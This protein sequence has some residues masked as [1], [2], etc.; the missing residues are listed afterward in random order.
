MRKLDLRQ[1]ALERQSASA[2]IINLRQL[3]ALTAVA[4]GSSISAAAEGLYRVSSAVTRSSA[5]LEEALGRPLFDRRARGTALNAYGELALKGATRMEQDFEAARSQLVAYGGFGARADV[6]SVFASILYERRLAI[7]ASQAEKRNM[8]AVAREFGITQPVISVALKDL[9]TGLGV[10]LFQRSARAD[11]NVHQRDCR[12]QLQAGAGPVAP[13]PAR[14]LW[15]A[16]LCYKAVLTSARCCS[17]E[18]KCCR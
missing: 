18:T 8:P 6:R 3:R 7:I 13:H 10:A 2:L 5:E 1:K 12:P 4:A 14:H 11:A 9:E 15:P 17:V 16:K